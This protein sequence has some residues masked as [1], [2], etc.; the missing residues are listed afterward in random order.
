MPKNQKNRLEAEEAELL[1][2]VEKGEWKSVRN[3]SAEISRAKDAAGEYF[4]KNAR[5]NIRLPERDLL[6]LKQIAANEGMPYQ[7]LISSVLHKYAASQFRK[8]A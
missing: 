3:K 5:V 4:K 1:E 8:A 2:S 7:T 6:L